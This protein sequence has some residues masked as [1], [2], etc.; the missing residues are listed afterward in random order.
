MVDNKKGNKINTFWVNFI[1]NNTS[2][3]VINNPHCLVD[4]QWGNCLRIPINAT[5]YQ[6]SFNITMPGYL[7]SGATINS[8]DVPNIIIAP[9]IQNAN[10]NGLKILL[11]YE[12]GQNYVPGTSVSNVLWLA[13]GRVLN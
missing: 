2:V 8:G 7:W 9:Y 11:D 6:V 5:P 3:P 10:A 13:I 1:G 12:I 4:V